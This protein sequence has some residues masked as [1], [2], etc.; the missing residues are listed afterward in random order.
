MMLRL[1]IRWLICCGSIFLALFI[2]PQWISNA[3]SW[4]VV[5]A[6][7]TVLWLINLLIRPIA[8][9]VSIVITIITMGIFSLIVNAAMVWLAD[10]MIP[11]IDI[12]SFWIYLFIAVII[13]IGNATL[14]P[15]RLVS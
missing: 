13:S 6:M 7:G 5:F 2:F 8:Q 12:R 14:T 3:G 11:A 4:V 1:L 10:L 15:K 9:V